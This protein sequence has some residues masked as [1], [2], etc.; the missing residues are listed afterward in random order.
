MG[1]WRHDPHLHVRVRHDCGSSVVSSNVP[2]PPP[3]RTSQTLI[4]LQLLARRRDFV[5]PLAQQ[6]R[7]ACAQP[8]Q[9]HRRCRQRP[10]AAH[11]QP[12]RMGLGC[13]GRIL[14]GR[15]WRSVRRLDILPCARTERPLLCRNGH[16]LR[17][18][19]LCSKVQRDKFGVR[20]VASRIVY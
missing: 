8:L 4:A 18:A 13:K 2:F 15:Y 20:M 10:H 14:L 17:C 16:A 12:G 6:D 11:A 1:Y 19:H 3:M 7:R 9:H 5:H